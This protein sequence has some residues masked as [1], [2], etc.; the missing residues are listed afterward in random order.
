MK[1]PAASACPMLKL[2]AREFFVHSGHSDLVTECP[3]G[4]TVIL[5]NE[6]VETQGFVVAGLPMVSVQF[7]PDMTAME[8]RDRLLA[9]TDGFS[10][11]IETD[12]ETFAKKFELGRDESTELLDAF[13]RSKGFAERASS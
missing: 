2:F 7:H 6:A 4:C 13:F 9:Y 10:D 12:A 5:G 8:A 3:S 11:R 1:S